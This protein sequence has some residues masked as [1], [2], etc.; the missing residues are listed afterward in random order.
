MGEIDLNGFFVP[1]RLFAQRL[2]LSKAWPKWL[3]QIDFERGSE[4][5]RCTA[6]EHTPFQADGN[7]HGLSLRR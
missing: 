2:S 1:R 7:S 3:A 5:D 4:L 6:S